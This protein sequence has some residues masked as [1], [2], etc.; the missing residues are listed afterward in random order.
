VDARGKEELQSEKRLKVEEPTLTGIIGI[1]VKE[2][3]EE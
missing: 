3:N 2:E 1:E